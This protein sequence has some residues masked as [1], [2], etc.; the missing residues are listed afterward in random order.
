MNTFFF[1]FSEKP[2]NLEIEVSTG[3]TNEYYCVIL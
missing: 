3:I 1:W 2:A